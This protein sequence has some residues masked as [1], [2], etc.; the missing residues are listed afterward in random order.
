[1]GSGSGGGGG[2]VVDVF[3][4]LSMSDYTGSKMGLVA[5]GKQRAEI[6]KRIA[7]AI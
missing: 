2:V 1:M 5:L 4:I 3:L 6:R 7:R